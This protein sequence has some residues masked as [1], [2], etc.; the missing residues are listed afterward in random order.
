MKTWNRNDGFVSRNFLGSS[1]THRGYFTLG[2]EGT[3]SGNLEGE[4]TLA[5][6]KMNVVE[7]LV[8]RDCVLRATDG[9]EYQD[10]TAALLQRFRFPAFFTQERRTE[11]PGS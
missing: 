10:Y 11:K 6:K 7:A 5:T 4:V 2:V 9:Y 1:G 8:S 3:A